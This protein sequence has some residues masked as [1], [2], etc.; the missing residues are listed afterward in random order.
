MNLGFGNTVKLS[1]EVD[2]VKRDG[3]AGKGVVR[4][5]EH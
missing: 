3:G 2:V 5:Y 4:G 1:V